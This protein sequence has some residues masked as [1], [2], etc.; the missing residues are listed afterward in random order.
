M[1]RFSLPASPGVEVNRTVLKATPTSHSWIKVRIK[2]DN[3]GSERPK[4]G[5]VPANY[6]VSVASIA[7]VTAAYDYEADP[8]EPEELTMRE[9]ESLQLFEKGED[10]SLVGRTG[11]VGFVPTAYLVHLLLWSNV[12][13]IYWLIRDFIG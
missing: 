5:L 4:E 12:S 1:R 3:P 6:V 9:N 7:T 11:A 2:I 10:W 13:S 8:S